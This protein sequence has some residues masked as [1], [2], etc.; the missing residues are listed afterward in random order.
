MKIKKILVA[1][2]GEIALRVM[3]TC[4]EMGIETVAVYSDADRSSPFVLFADEAWAL[5]G[6]TSQESYLRADKILEITRKSG[7]DAIHPG[8]GFLSENADFAEA[9]IKAGIIF[10]GPPAHAVR[11]MG[12]K[13]AARKKMI[14]GNVPVVPGTEEA[15]KDAQYAKKTAAQIGYPVLIKAA[16]GGGG[17]GMRLVKSESEFDEALGAAI[18]ETQAAFNDSSVY[19]EKF[20][21]EPHHIEFQILADSHGNVIHLGERDCSIQRR[22]QKVVEESPSALLDDDLRRRMGEAAVNA[23]KACNYVNAGTVEFLVDKRR[24]FYFLEMNTRLQVEHPVTELVSGLDLVREQILIAAG[25]PMSC[26]ENLSSFWGHAVECRIYAEDFHN[27]FAPSPGKIT[28]LRPADGPGIREDSGAAQGDEISLYYDPMISKLIAWGKDRP[29]AVERMLRALKEYEIGG[30]QTNIP[31]L[32]RVMENEKFK[33]GEYTTAF[34][35]ENMEQLKGVD[36][37]LLMTAVISAAL[38]G[39]NSNH[40]TAKKENAQ[41]IISPW[42]IIRRQK[43]LRIL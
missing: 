21:E 22:H 2:R 35:E 29:Q 34:I 8:Y 27:N 30:I 28:F 1:N 38:T 12:N 10:I 11:L 42:K 23:A 32:I 7:A 4:R 31:F 3:R 41:K 26:K 25:E 39:Q 36:E 17:K 18:R 37:K 20:V 40:K 5:G 15:I 33:R 6:V 43:N 14:A 13:T 19:L 24:N 9:V 16:A